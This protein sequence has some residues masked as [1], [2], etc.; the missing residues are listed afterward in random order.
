L[1]APLASAAACIWF[2]DGSA[3]KRIDTD[4]NA[5]VAEVPLD[6]P[7]R[8]VM[9]AGDC[10]VWALS[11]S[12][13]RLMQF[14]SSGNTVRDVSIHKD[15]DAG[16]P[17][18]LRIG[19]DPFD[20]SLWVADQ[21]SIAHLNADAS[22][23]IRKFM[24]PAHIE[25]FRIGMDQNLW[26]LGKHR[27]WR[28]SPDGAL[29]EE[30]ALD[31]VLKGEA[32]HFA[33]DELRGTIWVVGERQVARLDAAGAGEPNV[34]AAVP[35]GIGAFALDAITGRVWF[36]R[37]GSLDALNPDGTPF[38]RVGLAAL[39]LTGI[40]KLAYDP[41]SRSLWGGF[42]RQLVR[43]SD[44]GELV[45][46]VA[47]ADHDDETLGMPPFKVEPRLTLER[48]PEQG[49][50]NQRSPMFELQ[51]GAQC[52]GHACEAPQSYLSSLKLTAILNGVTVGAD[53]QFD[54]ATNKATRAASA[55]PE[56]ASSFQARL[57]D[58]F[59]HKSNA[60][61]TTITVDTIAPQFGLITPPSGTVLPAPQVTLSGST[62][63]PGSSVVLQNAQALNPQGAN[64]QFPQPPDFRFSWDLTLL[65]GTNAMQLSAIDPAGNVA[66]TTHTVVF[67]GAPGLSIQSPAAGAV[68]ADDNVTVSGI[69][70]GPPN[71]GIVVNG[72]VAAISANQ[73]FANVPL[74][75]GANT[76]TATATVTDG[77][78]AVSTVQ[79]TSSGASPTRVAASAMQGLAPLGVSFTITSDRE[80]RSVEGEFAPG[81]P[82]FVSPVTGPVSFTYDRPGAYEARFTITHI[83]ASTATRSVR[84]VVHDIVQLDGQIR[85][86]WSGM[87][88][89]LIR[90]DKAQAMQY[91]N[92]QAKE[93]YGPVLDALLP[94][95]PQ[96][97]AG[98][99]ALQTSTINDAVG[100]YAIN[101][102]IDGV[103]RIFFIY[104]LRDADGLWRLDSM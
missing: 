48:P 45:A 87:T 24:A 27:L 83:D 53:F 93:K 91:L 63:E 72:V 68:I 20:D 58:V 75:S 42:A 89:A 44:T 10:S 99:S 30:R 62:N 90:G 38:V 19:L 52:N 8:L 92:H 78:Q 15:L 33:V 54:P 37:P 31:R 98:F 69:W 41:A 101:R 79:V 1:F 97:L 77:K 65:P 29:L 5:V 2:A 25:R 51:Y 14:D 60:I 36:G 73:F 23:V 100:E 16:L 66:T 74:A 18:G 67:S 26:I 64:P 71:T 76:I 47:A 4:T 55:L 6:D 95:M 7:R 96:I 9:N 17:K 80:I 50:V 43:F 46:A 13:Q 56:G 86:V 28:F 49:I 11:G 88:A 21:R 35:E 102:T 34:V 81:S 61:D 59:G 103:N 40:H 32:R 12:G 94:S 70:S 104:F 57:T 84:I 3:I 22:W 85:Q 39:G 82:F